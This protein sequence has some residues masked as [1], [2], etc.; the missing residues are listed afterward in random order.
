MAE[1]QPP[2]APSTLRTTHP[3]LTAAEE[4]TPKD[5]VFLVMF[6]G[7]IESAE[8]SFYLS[9][10]AIILLYYTIHSDIVPRL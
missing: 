10:F 9:M 1:G 7:Q 8:A 4:D 5:P 2:P 6:T 3:Q